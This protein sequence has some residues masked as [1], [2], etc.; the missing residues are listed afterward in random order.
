MTTIHRLASGAS[1]VL[2][3]GSPE[4]VLA[5]CASVLDRGG[6]RAL[7]DQERARV[8]ADV[9]ALAADGLRVQAF[10]RRTLA[11]DPPQAPDD[12]EVDL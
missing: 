9:D 12:V 2:T 4:A 8:S 5:V 7:S 11:G 1:E 10:A 3:K 6:V